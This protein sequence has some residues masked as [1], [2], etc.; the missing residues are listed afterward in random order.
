MRFGLCTALIRLWIRLV[1]NTVLPARDRTV[2]A[3]ETTEPGG[4]RSGG[5]G[6]VTIESIISGLLAVGC[7]GLSHAPRWLTCRSHDPR[8]SA[9]TPAQPTQACAAARRLRRALPRIRPGRHV[10]L[11]GGSQLH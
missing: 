4:N 11:C 3:G 9:A 5:E 6:R 10:S 7:K 8:L 2:T 1:M